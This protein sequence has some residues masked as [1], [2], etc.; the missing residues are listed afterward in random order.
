MPASCRMRG[1]IGRL[2]RLI[3]LGV[4]FAWRTILEPIDYD[5]RSRPEGPVSA[6]SRAI[7]F[8]AFGRARVAMR[9]SRFGGTIC[10]AANRRKNSDRSDEFRRYQR[11]IGQYAL[12][13]GRHAQTRPRV[14]FA[15]RPRN[16]RISPTTLESM[17]RQAIYGVSELAGSERTSP[18]QIRHETS[19]LP[20]EVTC[21]GSPS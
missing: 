20:H 12:L 17:N 5:C 16:L 1:A 18:I 6:D 19:L 14:A 4:Q 11:K 7:T 15:M 8:A 21:A 3:G 2:C 10:P 13:I 9:L